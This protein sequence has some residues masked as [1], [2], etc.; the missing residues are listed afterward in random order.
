MDH[1]DLASE[2]CKKIEN[3]TNGFRK[4]ELL[5]SKPFHFR[6]SG[7]IE[8]FRF[9]KPELIHFLVLHIGQISSNLHAALLLQEHGF[10]YELQILL[11]GIYESE[12]KIRFLIHGLNETGVS[13]QQSKF[14]KNYFN[15]NTRYGLE[16]PKK[17]TPQRQLMEKNAQSFKRDLEVLKEWR[18]EENKGFSEEDALFALNEVY[19]VSSNYVHGR[20]PEQMSFY[21]YE[22]LNFTVDGTRDNNQL[23][24]AAELMELSVDRCT[25]LLVV[26]A[27]VLFNSSKIPRDCELFKWAVMDSGIDRLGIQ[28]LRKIY[29]P[30]EK[31]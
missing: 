10:L 20:Y 29:F 1:N 16:S 28:T 12:V 27:L 7:N 5:A 26:V 21:N 6:D 8:T 19:R 15:D 3:F 31:Y 17:T 22:N 30:N 18:V 9:G 23:F 13:K 2:S 14:L 25:S 11:R 4:L 24:P